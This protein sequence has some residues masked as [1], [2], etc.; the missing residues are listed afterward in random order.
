MS[1]GAEVRK[2][3]KDYISRGGD[4]SKIAKTSEDAVARQIYHLVYSSEMR[5]S[6]GR[7]FTL[8][9]KFEANGI[10]FSQKKFPLVERIEIVRKMLAD[11]VESGGDVND[12]KKTDKEYQEVHSLKM[13]DASGR[14]LTVEEKFVALGQPRGAKMSSDTRRD[15]QAAIAKYL[16]DG[17][18]IYIPKSKLP[19][20]RAEYGSF[21][22]GQRDKG[23]TGDFAFQTNMRELGF[24]YSEMFY[25][26]GKVLDLP[27][28]KDS[29]GFVDAY[30]KDTKMDNFVKISAYK[31]GLPIPVFVGLVGN[32]DLEGCYLDTEYFGF[33]KSELE[34]YLKTHDNFV[35]LSKIDKPLYEKVRHVRRMAFNAGGEDLTTD[36]V[37]CLLGF[38]DVENDFGR[39]GETSDASEILNMIRPIAAAKGGKLSRSDIP[40]KEYRKLVGMIASTGATTK[41]FFNLY[42]I[43][44]DG[45]EGQRL[46]KV[47]VNGYPCMKEM[48][49]ERDRILTEHGVSMNGECKKEDLFDV[50][51][52]A[53]L[54]AFEKYRKEIFNF[55][56]IKYESVAQKLE[57]ENASSVRQDAKS[58]V[59]T[60]GTGGKV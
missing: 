1:S 41:A 24:N 35:G 25:Q 39:S 52:S 6:D 26:Y 4:P 58:Q 19:F 34:R 56:S 28:F 21:A 20:F 16:A 13:R 33:L 55:E 53:S 11:F 44:Y 2:I 46:A 7:R 30:R 40:E 45:K 29:N 14:R 36:D 60:K 37:V 57:E 50:L 43:D 51:I 18:D 23:V 10:P 5:D 9:E 3:Y 59:S 42:D 22:R 49:A 15:A 31:L 17:G 12:L 27:K 47:W 48:R 54:K 32:C 8:A 38:D